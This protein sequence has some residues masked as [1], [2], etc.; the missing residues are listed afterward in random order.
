MNRYLVSILLLL[1]LSLHA[2]H[3]G[4]SLSCRLFS[5]NGSEV[6]LNDYLGKVVY[7]DFWASW[8]PPCVRSFP[9]MNKLLDQ[10]HDKGLHVVAI[11]LDEQREDAEQFLS[12]NNINFQVMFDNEQRECAR[13]FA[14]QAMPS[15]Y[16]VDKKGKIRHMHLG[17]KQGETDQLIAKVKQL[18]DE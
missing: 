7:V 13:N 9:F 8:C 18:L 2:E 4:E 16:L 6:Q 1:P 3:P 14:V 5:D 10:H 15:S 12:Q 17:F 11:N